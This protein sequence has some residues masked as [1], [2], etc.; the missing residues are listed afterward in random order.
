MKGVSET[1]EVGEKVRSRTKAFFDLL[2]GVGGE[3]VDGTVISSE[4]NVCPR[5]YHQRET[6]R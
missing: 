1:A 5:G 4:K 2:K 3:G 6:L